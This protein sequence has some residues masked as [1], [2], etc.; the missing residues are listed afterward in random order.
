MTA[1]MINNLG[2]PEGKRRRRQTEEGDVDPIFNFMIVATTME[3]TDPT[4]TGSG[5]GGSAGAIVVSYSL[6]LASLLLAVLMF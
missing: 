4:S 2:Q 6:L 5:D 3:T 1:N